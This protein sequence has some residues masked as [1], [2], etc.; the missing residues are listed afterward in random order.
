VWKVLAE[1][2][3][4]FVFAYAGDAGKKID[5]PGVLK[6]FR[7][8]VPQN[9]QA[10][11]GPW[12]RDAIHGEYYAKAAGNNGPAST[13]QIHMRYAYKV[14]E[15]F[16]MPA[17]YTAQNGVVPWLDLYANSP[18][19]PITI[20]YTISWPAAPQM[21][22]VDTLVRQ[23]GGLP[24][25][26]HALGVEILYQQSVSNKLGPTAHLIDPVAARTHALHVLPPGIDTLN[27]Q[28]KLYFPD[29]PPHLRQRFAY[30]PVQ[31]ELQFWGEI[32]SLV[33]DDHL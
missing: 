31:R 2:P 22:L 6:D 9:T 32:V 19:V 3:P 25:I 29:L 16:F 10:I 15:S 26:E 24:N 20:P 7:F 4:T 23:K 28:G 1:Q 5:P 30:D 12:W 21:K 18:G 33:G 27:Y 11:L 8:D 13:A 17:G 14:Q